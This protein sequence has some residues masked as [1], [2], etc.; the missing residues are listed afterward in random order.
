MGGED[1]AEALR[2]IGGGGLRVQPGELRVGEQVGVGGFCHVN[3]SQSSNGL[4]V[5]PVRTTQIGRGSF[6]AIHRAELRGQS[7]AVKSIA[8]VHIFILFNI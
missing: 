6:G 5:S 3:S 7:V 8:Q 2:L 1:L 4:F